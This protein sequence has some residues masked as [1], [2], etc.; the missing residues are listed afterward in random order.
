MSKYSDTSSQNDSLQYKL[1]DDTGDTHHGISF[2]HTLILSTTYTSKAQVSFKMGLKTSN[3]TTAGGLLSEFVQCQ[4]FTHGTQR[5][6]M[7]I[8]QI[9]RSRC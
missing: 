6:R 8:I 4:L 7:Q 9:D 2:K 5:L 3:I 1:K